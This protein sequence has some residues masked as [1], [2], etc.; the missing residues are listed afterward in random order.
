LTKVPNWSDVIGAGSANIGANFALTSAE[1]SAAVN[2]WFR[3]CVAPAGIPAGAKRPNE[4]ST[5]KLARPSVRHPTEPRL[6]G[7][8]GLDVGEG[9]RRPE[10]QGLNRPEHRA[11]Q[12]LTGLL[13]PRRRKRPLHGDEFSSV[14]V[15]DGSVTAYRGRRLSGRS[16]WAAAFRR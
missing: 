13:A 1:A 3:R 6:Q 4:V 16:T 8:Q 2:A 7:A 5:L 11:A 14:K 9:A 12:H 10:V 15:V